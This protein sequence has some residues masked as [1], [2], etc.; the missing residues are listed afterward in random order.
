ML[1]AGVVGLALFCLVFSISNP[2]LY[3]GSLITYFRE[4]PGLGILGLH[5]ASLLVSYKAFEYSFRFFFPQGFAQVK[6]FFAWLVNLFI[7]LVTTWR[8]GQD[9]PELD[10]LSQR[11]SETQQDLISLCQYGVYAIVLTNLW[12]VSIYYDSESGDLGWY[13]TLMV[14]LMN[15]AFFFI[16]DDWAIIADYSRRLKGRMMLWDIVRVHGFNLLLSVPLFAVTLLVLPSA[17]AWISLP[18]L[19][20]FL[21]WRYFYQFADV[22]KARYDI[23]TRDFRQNIRE[24]RRR[25]ARAA[26]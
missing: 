5:I 16:I 11:Q 6:Q 1:P 7:G 10:N 22:G 21:F 25:S 20:I 14:I 26:T 23:A 12:L 4:Q 18:L 19:V 9:D 3:E 17:S 24:S 2:L 15:W 13:V 8:P